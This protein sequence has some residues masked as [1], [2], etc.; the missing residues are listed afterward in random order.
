MSAATFHPFP[1]LPLEIRQGIWEKACFHWTG[2]RYGIH[3]I[4]LDQNRQLA[5]LDCA[6]HANGPRNRSAYLWHAG[7]WTACKESRDIVSKHWH[8]YWSDIQANTKDKNLGDVIWFHPKDPPYMMGAIHRKGDYEP[9]HQVVDIDYDRF[10]ITAGS[11]EPLLNNWKLLNIEAE[12]EWG[13][14]FKENLRNLTVEFD[15]SWNLTLN[16][17]TPDRPI[18]DYHPSLAFLI[19]I[20]L[21]LAHEDD[22]PYNIRLIDKNVLWDG[23]IDARTYGSVQANPLYV[24]CDHEYLDLTGLSFAEDSPLSI[25]LHRL[26]RAIGSQLAKIQY[27]VNTSNRS[28]LTLSPE[29]LM[30][31]VVKRDNQRQGSFA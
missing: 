2:G 6:W 29:Q 3:Y 20:L 19:R 12:D 23:K 14:N 4:K 28:H 15:P 21:D 30:R 25:F 11:W 16:N 22:F 24:D 8:K 18:E 9:W 13:R 10:C 26:D 7:L 31:F 17:L 5:P 27:G 1:R